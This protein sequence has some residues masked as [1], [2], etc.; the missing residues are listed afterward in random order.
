MFSR[1][2]SAAYCIVK[3]LFSK[4]RTTKQL[5][6]KAAIFL[7]AAAIGLSGCAGLTPPSEHTA[8]NAE[9]LIGDSDSNAAQTLN[10]ETIQTELDGIE[11]AETFPMDVD[12]EVIPSDLWDRVTTNFQIYE[13]QEAEYYSRVDRWRNWYNDRPNKM[14]SASK[15]AAPYLYYITQELEARGMPTELALLPLVESGFDPYAFSW[16]RAAGLW[17]FMPR[18]GTYMGLR[19]DWWYDGRRDV[20]EA[21]NAALNYL[22]YLHKFFD[23]DWLKA[24]AAY[25][26]G[27][28]TVLKAVKHNRAQGLPTDY[29]SLTKLRKE[30]LDYV[31]KLLAVSQLV[32]ERYVHDT[33]LTEIADAPYFTEV[34]L[35]GQMDLMQL[36]GLAGIDMATLQ[37]LNPAFN[38]WSTAPEGPHRLLVPVTA[39]QRFTQKLANLSA[40][41]YIRWKKHT[42]RSGDSLSKVA[43]KYRTTAEAVAYANA[44]DGDSLKVGTNLLI[45]V[46]RK[47]LV[48][49]RMTAEQLAV[50]QQAKRQI[51]HVVTAGD[52][53]WKVAKSYNV[54][55]SQIKR[56]NRLDDS[57][58]QLGQKLKIKSGE[59]PKALS[60]MRRVVYR[61]RSGDTLAKVAKRYN[62][63]PE[64]IADKNKLKSADPEQVL[65]RGKILRIELDVTLQTARL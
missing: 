52:S 54:D 51:T 30:T 58:L 64:S 2:G 4:Q 26:A 17:Q 32:D 7:V 39:K 35:P 29:W 33:Q 12:G 44:I 60:T 43:S 41:E 45:P 1:L 57:A 22:E 46:G 15:R 23:G 47:D 37:R 40:D 42:V 34:K 10:H 21:T 5:T 16:A 14:L 61:T 28:G 18:T 27:E 48:A 36:A 38:Q 59:A 20:V 6:T 56:W 31:P 24:I 63:T 13:N 9:E 55:V 25:N 11:M 65:K 3:P 53:L 62:V 19:Q 8:V 50:R 49:Y